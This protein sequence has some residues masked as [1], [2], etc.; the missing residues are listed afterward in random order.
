MIYFLGKLLHPHFGTLSFLRLAEYISARAIGAALTA[1]ILTLWLT[2]IVIRHLHRKGLVDQWRNTG[3]DAAF[4]KAGTPSMGGAVVVGCVLV[5]C[6]AWCNL[7]N[8]FLVAVLAGMAWF[9]M[10]GF[11]DDRA[12]ARFHSGDLGMSEP[13]K[14]MLQGL[15]AAAL[16]A[17]MLGPWSP[18]PADQMGAFYVPFLKFPVFQSVWAYAPIVFLFV[19]VVGNSVNI[20][21]GMDGLAI[22]PSVFVLGVL[23]LFGYFLG[24]AIYARYLNYPLLA[25]AGELAVFASAFAGAGIGFLWFNAYP[26]Q[27]FLGDTGSMA[28]GGAIATACVVLQQEVLFLILGGMFLTEAVTSQIQDKIGVRWLGR[29]IF[30]RAPIHHQMQHKGLAETKVVIRLWIVSGI[31]ALAALAT[32]KLR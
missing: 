9:G 22:V 13:K 28:I 32:L 14:L 21:D 18:L 27:I 26:A 23:G 8:M 20:A 1:I 4:D 29:R 6:L 3:V 30:M 10:I 25:G 5:S 16:V 31:L 15:F 24:N 7:S 19:I 17:L 12:K 2:P 11:L